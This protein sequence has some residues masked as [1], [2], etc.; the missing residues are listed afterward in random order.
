MRLCEECYHLIVNGDGKK[1]CFSEGFNLR[2]SSSSKSCPYFI[3]KNEPLKPCPDCQ[4]IHRMKSDFCK[5]CKIV[6]N[7][8]LKYKEDYEN[9]KVGK[10]SLEEIEN[11]NKEIHFVEDVISSDILD[12]I[13]KIKNELNNGI[14]SPFFYKKINEEITLLERQLSITKEIV[15]IDEMINGIISSINKVIQQ[16]KD[17][18]QTEF[19]DELDLMKIESKLSI[20][21]IKL[22][23]KINNL[24]DEYHLEE[25]DKILNDLKEIFNHLKK[26]EDISQVKEIQKKFIVFRDNIVK[27]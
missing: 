8:D 16:V 17:K 3:N 26:I 11:M 20:Q 7:L 23:S 2:D 24:I 21:I 14:K 13:Q 10:Y 25:S 12:L 4:G 19:S 9:E 22:V 15:K 6:K 27:I 1:F 5:N 18:N